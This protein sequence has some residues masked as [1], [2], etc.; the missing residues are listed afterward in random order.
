MPQGSFFS[1]TEMNELRVILKY[2][3]TSQV[4]TAMLVAANRS[5]G[6]LASAGVMADDFQTAELLPIMLAEAGNG[7]L[8]RGAREAVELPA[9]AFRA[10]RKSLRNKA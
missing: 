9:G 7:F 6:L 5:G 10:R 8:Y 2:S 4:T 3:E 1:Q